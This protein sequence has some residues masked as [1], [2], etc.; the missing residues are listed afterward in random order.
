[1]KTKSIGIKDLRHSIASVADEVEQKNTV[2]QVLRRSRPSFKIVPISTVVEEEW[3][4]VVDFT[5]EK[6]DGMSVQDAL[7][8]LE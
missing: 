4:T 6:N 2:F 5:T 8:T 1:M 7:N 3:E